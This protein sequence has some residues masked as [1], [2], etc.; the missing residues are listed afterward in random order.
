MS[1]ENQGVF[2]LLKQVTFRGILKFSGLRKWGHFGGICSR[3]SAFW[4]AGGA[5][6]KASDDLVLS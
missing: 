2:K 1:L 4:L 5:G 6:P 3:L